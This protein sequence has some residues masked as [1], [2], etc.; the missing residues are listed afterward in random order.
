MR[1]LSFSQD[2][3]SEYGHWTNTYPE[4]VSEKEHIP[5]TPLP[6]SMG[7]MVNKAQGYEK[8]K[9]KPLDEPL[10]SR[11]RAKERHFEKGE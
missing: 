3:L 10:S 9:Y 8:K 6:S 4:R 5:P 2:S 7:F 1:S 11:E